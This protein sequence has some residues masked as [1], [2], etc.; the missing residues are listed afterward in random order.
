MDMNMDKGYT[1][2]QVRT[3]VELGRK[4]QEC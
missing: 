3:M 1:Y 4:N 2:Y